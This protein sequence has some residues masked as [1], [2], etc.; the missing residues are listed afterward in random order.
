MTDMFIYTA[1]KTQGV[2]NIE[3][4]V[5]RYFSHRDYLRQVI[6][7]PFLIYIKLRSLL[8]ALFVV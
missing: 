8:Y 4:S 5:W 6:T 7:I 3:H 1:L 2:N